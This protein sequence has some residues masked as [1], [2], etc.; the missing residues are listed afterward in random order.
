MQMNTVA[1]RAI[2]KKGQPFILTSHKSPLAV[3]WPCFIEGKL[4]I[5]GL[6]RMGMSDATITHLEGLCYEEI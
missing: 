2:E 6:K 5:E 3:C 4:D 1:V